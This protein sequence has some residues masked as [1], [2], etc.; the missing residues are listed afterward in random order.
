MSVQMAL[1]GMSF[2]VDTITVDGKEYTK[3]PITG[4]WSVASK[5]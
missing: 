1:L 3:D 5:S 2:N 4:L